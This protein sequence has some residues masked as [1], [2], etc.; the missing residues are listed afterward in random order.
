MFLKLRV[1]RAVGNLRF[2]DSLLEALARS[3]GMTRV[4]KAIPTAWSDEGVVVAPAV[5]IRGLRF[6]GASQRSIWV[7]SCGRREAASARAPAMS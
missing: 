6:T 4:R 1:V 5:R 3:D 2:T 7:S